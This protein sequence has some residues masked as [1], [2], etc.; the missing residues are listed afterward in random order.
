[1]DA[2]ATI[3]SQHESFP[4]APSLDKYIAIEKFV[5]EHIAKRRDESGRENAT[6]N[7]EEDTP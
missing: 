5:G 1:M 4:E 3:H 6:T 7:A 2:I